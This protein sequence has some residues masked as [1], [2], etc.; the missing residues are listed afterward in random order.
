MTQFCTPER[1]STVLLVTEVG[2]EAK[3]AEGALARP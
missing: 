2:E 1:E 3:L